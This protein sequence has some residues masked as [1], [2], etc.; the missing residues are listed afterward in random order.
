MDEWLG[1]AVDGGRRAV[2]ST[3]DTSRTMVNSRAWKAVPGD[4]DKHLGRVCIGLLRMS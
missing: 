2:E 1:A 4:S 3:C